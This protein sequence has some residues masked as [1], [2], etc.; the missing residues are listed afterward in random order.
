VEYLSPLKSNR[1]KNKLIKRQREL[2][3]EAELS[4]PRR[5]VSAAR[6]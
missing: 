3:R 1:I 2:D 5:R 4:L 6:A